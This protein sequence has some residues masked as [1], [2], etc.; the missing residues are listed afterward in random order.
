V[1]RCRTQGALAAHGRP[2][3]QGFTV[4]GLPTRRG[5]VE[6]AEAGWL[7]GAQQRRRRMVADDGSGELL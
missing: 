1:G 7:D 4:R 3:R 5:G 2:A 6:V